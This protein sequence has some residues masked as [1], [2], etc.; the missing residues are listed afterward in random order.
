MPTYKNISNND[1][2]LLY[3]AVKIQIDF[4]TGGDIPLSEIIAMVDEYLA[5]KIDKDDLLADIAGQ[6]DTMSGRIDDLDIAIAVI[7][8]Q[9]IPAPL[10]TILIGICENQ[11]NQYRIIVRELKVWKFLINNLTI[12]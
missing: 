12:E 7:P 11:Q 3:D 4:N 6:L 1:I 8:N 10:K 2:G 9:A 5:G